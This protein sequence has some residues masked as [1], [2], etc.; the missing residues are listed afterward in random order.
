MMT[1]DPNKLEIINN[2]FLVASEVM[3]LAIRILSPLDL[4]DRQIARAVLESL[5]RRPTAT[6]AVS[7][8]ARAK[9]SDSND[10]GPSSM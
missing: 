9:V 8:R 10:Q 1:D 6:A 5:P 3:S 4:D 7:V 2:N